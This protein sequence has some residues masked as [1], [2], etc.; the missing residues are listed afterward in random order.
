MASNDH[1]DD[2]ANK[3]VITIA[4]I[5]A[6]IVAQKAV[7]AGWRLVRGG[8]PKKDDDSSVLEAVL[9]A[10]ATAAAVAAARNLA[11]HRMRHQTAQSPETN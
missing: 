10:A 7:S 5:V 3:V 6:G 4:A 11:A 9:F 2:G 1:S 8:T